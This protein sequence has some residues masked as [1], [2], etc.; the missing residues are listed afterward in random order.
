MNK[1]LV[2][3]GSGYFG[4]ILAQRLWEKGFQVSVFDLEDAP[5]RD[6]A[7]AFYQ[8]DIG[9][10]EAVKKACQGKDCVY[11]CVALVPV[12]REVKKFW[13]VNYD[14]TKNLLQACLE[15]KVR[16]VIH[17]SSSAV[18]GVPGKNPVDD[19]AK[20][21]PG[22]E[23]GRAKFGAEEL[24]HEYAGKGLDVSIIRPRTIIGHGRLGIMQILFE[25]VRQGRNLPVL[26]KG[27]NLYQFVH[28][29][30]LADACLKAAQQKNPAVYNIGAEKFGSMRETLEGLIAYAGAKS[31][32]VSLPVKP[33]V[34]LMK[35]TSK[36]HLSPLGPYHI[37]MYGQTMY[38]DLARAKTE[39]NWSP[40]FS[41]IEMFCESYDWY[42]K[43]RDRILKTKSS[44]YHRA[45]VRM[46]ILKLVSWG[47]QIL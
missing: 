18:F 8:G 31:K 16:K 46:G 14:G 38:F 26:G 19:S 13:S 32:V 20:P 29:D 41:N 36:L 27:D 6:S 34:A 5:D 4:S 28:A 12:A 35:L 37:L 22:E 15:S 21:V 9:D 47:L 1:I 7:L 30:D 33:A 17:L 2:T 25:W 10:S 40:G 3:G 42:L 39:L 23:Y 43:N 24:C 44:S 45:P 11:H